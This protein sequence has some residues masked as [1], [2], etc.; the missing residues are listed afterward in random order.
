MSFNAFS[1]K[2][3]SITKIIESDCSNPFVKSVELQ[4]TGTVDFGS[5]VILNYMQNGSP[6]EDT[7]IDISALGVVTDSFVYIV[8]NLALMQAEFPST[9]FDTSNTVVVSTS[10]N[11]N[12]G[13]QI[14]LNNNVVSQFGKTETDADDDTIWEHDDSVVSRKQE[15]ADNG[16]WDESHWNYSGKNTLDGETS[17]NGGAGIESYLASL[18]NGYPLAYGSGSDGSDPGF[19]LTENSTGSFNFTPQAPLNRPPLKVYYHIPSGDI[20]TMPILMSFHGSDRD[21][22]NHRDFWI[23]MANSN[24]FIVIAPEFSSSNYPGLGDNYLMSNIFDDGDNP[25]AATFND[26]NEWT[27]STLDPLFEYV[28]EAISGTQEQYSG[29]GHSGGAQFLH[30]FVTYLPGSKLATAVCSNAGWYTVPE[31]GVSF[32][33]GID[34]GQLPTEDL[35]AAFSRKLIIHL[36]KN[37]TNSNAGLRRNAVVDEQQGTNRLVRGQYYFETAQTTA[38]N[39]GATYNWEKHELEDVGH[40]PQLMADDALQYL[41]SNLLSNNNTIISKELL[42]FP[43][44]VDNLLTFDNSKIKSSKVQVFSISG[45]LLST[46]NFSNFSSNQKIVF[47]KFSKGIY[48]LKIITEKGAITQKIIKK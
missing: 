38:A 41:L 7:Q 17:C 48:F 47:S 10:T 31:N 46:N 22:D 18:G 15:I 35:T 20:K 44:P 34:N 13:Y 33:Y 43:N 30:R 12:D 40:N 26:K 36:G 6:W 37:D 14:F 32:P 25:T 19:S 39:M 42:V 45:E 3:V 28:K 8:R 24:G 1:Q 21:G 23:D 29:W 4:V 16:I 27:F 11:G 2:N 9:T 5:E